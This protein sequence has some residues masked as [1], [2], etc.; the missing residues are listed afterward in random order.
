MK[1]FLDA[2]SEGKMEQARAYYDPVTGGGILR[3]IQEPKL[4]A[5]MHQAQLRLQWSDLPSLDPEAQT[6]IVQADSAEGT[7]RMYFYLV[8]KEGRWYI[9][10]YR[11]TD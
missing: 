5:V 8:K 10:S 3:E 11:V 2:I 6:I 7:Y 4:I 1:A 9:Q